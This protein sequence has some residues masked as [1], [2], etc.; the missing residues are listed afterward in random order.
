MRVRFLLGLACASLGS[1]S[2]AA[3]SAVSLDVFPSWATAQEDGGKIE[4]FRPSDTEAETIAET[5]VGMRVNLTEFVIPGS[6]VQAKPVADP[7]RADALVRIKHEYT[8]GSSFRYDIEVT[9]F[10]EGDLNLADFL[11]R[12]DGTSMEDVPELSIFVEAM[13]PDETLQPKDLEVPDPNKVGGYKKLLIAAGVVWGLGLLALI[14]GFRRKVDE[15]SAEGGV[16]R[17]SLAD[18]LRPLVEEARTS[19]ISHE[20][21]AELERLLLAHWRK[22]RGLEDTPAA[23]AIAQ[24]R[25]DEEAGPL[26]RQLEEWLHR[27]AGAAG[28][29]VD[30]AALLEPYQHVAT[31]VE[32]GGAVG[33]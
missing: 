32:A 30:V 27:P 28:S 15:E 11:E 17:L 5:S 21:R 10:V 13:L 1:S 29:S 25:S 26:L 8:H 14:F 2:F 24:L 3:F 12:K 31:E 18:R 6:A 22:R 23:Q 19:E 9:P 20:R 7:G 4:F 33:A 16:Q